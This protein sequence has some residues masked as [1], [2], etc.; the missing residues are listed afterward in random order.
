M[1]SRHGRHAP[2][3]HPLLAAGLA[4]CLV[5]ATAMSSMTGMARAEPARAELARAELARGGQALAGAADLTGA[6]PLSCVAASRKRRALAARMTRDISAALQ[7]RVSVVGLTAADTRTGITCK[8]HPW[9][10]FYSASVVKVI[11]LGALLHELMVQHLSLTPEQVT[12]TRQMITVS[13]NSAASTLWKE[14]GRRNLQQFLDLARMSHTTLGQGGFWGLTKVVA[15]DELLLLRVLTVKN[16]VLDKPSRAYAL[17]LMAEVIPAQRWGV[18]AGAPTSVRVH[19][20]NGWLPYPVL[21]II[22]SIGAFT[23]QHRTYRI[24]VL[25]RDNPSML[26]GVDTVQAVAEVINHDFN[27][28]VTA[29]I[30]PSVPSPSWGTPDEQIPVL[31]DRR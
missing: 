8:W 23:S 25:T 29:V 3:R 16:D 22:N 12:L 26:Y 11:I 13:S 14:V 4:L 21:W 2:L 30:P 17:K 20:K 5:T 18:P 1:S 24:V 19:V 15:H 28:G 31:A 10:Q 7:G 6:P 9:W 27:L